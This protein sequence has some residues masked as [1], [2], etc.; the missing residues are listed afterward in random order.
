MRIIL[1]LAYKIRSLCAVILCS[2]APR[3]WSMNLGKPYA[4]AAKSFGYSHRAIV[5]VRLPHPAFAT[6][7]FIARFNA[8]GGRDD[9]LDCAGI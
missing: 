3:C 5:M 8:D 1:K 4:T 6:A 7:G 2:Y 9:F